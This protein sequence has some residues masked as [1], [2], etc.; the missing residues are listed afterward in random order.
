M[1]PSTPA[2]CG[3]TGGLPGAFL[4]DVSTLVDRLLENGMPRR[5][6]QIAMRF[7]AP[8]DKAAQFAIITR[9]EAEEIDRTRKAIDSI[10]NGLPFVPYRVLA[11][12]RALKKVLKAPL[13]TMPLSVFYQIRLYYD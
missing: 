8:V 5:A 12:T 3:S 1:G 4:D 13:T 11:A 2:S 9:S 10:S 6:R 7:R